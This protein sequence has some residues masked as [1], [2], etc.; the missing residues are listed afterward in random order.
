MGQFQIGA[1]VRIF[2]LAAI[3][4]WGTF[5][6]LPLSFCALFYF[7]NCECGL[8]QGCSHQSAFI[9]S[10]PPAR[11]TSP[12]F[13]TPDTKPL[14]PCRPDSKGLKHTCW[15]PSF[16]STLSRVGLLCSHHVRFLFLFFFALAGQTNSHSFPLSSVLAGI[17][18]CIINC[19]SVSIRLCLKS[20]AHRFSSFSFCPC[21]NMYFALILRD[22]CSSTGFRR[23]SHVSHGSFVKKKRRRGCS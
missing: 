2:I 6:F 9:Y 22:K 15:V 18:I 17:R 23:S 11:W 4:L 7:K 10:L 13:T 5:F 8:P 20:K 12:C 16:K 3:C 14:S 1:P 19:L 21:L